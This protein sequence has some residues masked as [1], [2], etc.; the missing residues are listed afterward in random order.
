MNI[1]MGD[2]IGI[3]KEMV[4]LAMSCVSLVHRP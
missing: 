4:F 2:E 3:G 1:I